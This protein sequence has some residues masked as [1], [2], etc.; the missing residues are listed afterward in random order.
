MVEIVVDS[1]QMPLPKVGHDER[2]DV[3]RQSW[4]GVCLL[5]PDGRV[6]FFWLLC[7]IER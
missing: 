1:A 7:R 6:V 3:S 5:H 4:Q 2:K